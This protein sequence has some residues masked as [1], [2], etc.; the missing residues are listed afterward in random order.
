MSGSLMVRGP[1]ELLYNHYI[2]K[3]ASKI[4][5]SHVN[6]RFPGSNCVCGIPS[7]TVKNQSHQLP[8][9]YIPSSQIDIR[10]SLWGGAYTKGIVLSVELYWRHHP[11]I[12]QNAAQRQHRYSSLRL[13]PHLYPRRIHLKTYTL[14]T[15]NPK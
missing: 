6:G 3:I 2:S 4:G 12:R 14:I 5:R 13:Y 7:L 15:S 9:S 10:S 1:V 8:I 11:N